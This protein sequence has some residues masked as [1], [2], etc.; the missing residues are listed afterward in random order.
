MESNCHLLCKLLGLSKK[1][2]THPCPVEAHSFEINKKNFRP[3]I[4]FHI[5]KRLLTKINQCLKPIK[6]LFF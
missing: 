1:V 6:Y 5:D 4:E 3:D 2:R